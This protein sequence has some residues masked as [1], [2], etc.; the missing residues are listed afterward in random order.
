MWLDNNP[1]HVG[2]KEST[3]RIVWIGV[4][5]GKFMMNSMC[6]TPIVDTILWDNHLVLGLQ[7]HL[8]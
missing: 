6:D 8:T 2:E 5:I 3:F 1:A 7:F 4:C